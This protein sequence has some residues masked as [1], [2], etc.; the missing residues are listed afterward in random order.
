MK[1][2]L[3]I[4]SDDYPVGVAID[5]VP[6]G[7]IL[8]STGADQRGAAVGNPLVWTTK[9]QRSAVYHTSKNCM[10]VL[11]RNRR[12]IGLNRAKAENLQPCSWCGHG[13]Q[14]RAA[15]A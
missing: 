2:T 3:N 12:W 14:T 4:I 8:Q 11:P 5:T 15:A 6:S 9:N 1:I 7:D 10:N 13:G